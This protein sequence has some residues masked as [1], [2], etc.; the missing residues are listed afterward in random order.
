MY[1]VSWEDVV[2]CEWDNRNFCFPSFAIATDSCCKAGHVLI[3]MWLG[4]QGQSNFNQC[5]AILDW[6]KFIVWLT[7]VEG[8]CWNIFHRSVVA[9]PNQCILTVVG[10]TYKLQCPNEGKLHHPPHLCEWKTHFF[11]A[12]WLNKKTA[13]GQLDSHVSN[14]DS[15]VS[16]YLVVR[17]SLLVVGGLR[18]LKSI[19]EKLGSVVELFKSLMNFEKKEKSG[20]KTYTLNPRCSF[21]SDI[22]RQF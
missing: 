19:T 21:F 4:Q 1:N 18:M 15:L 13:Y 9:A 11:S 7:C 17:L 2:C 6:L 20:K 10:A 16:L 5:V 22:V 8:T 14:G 3:E 12:Q